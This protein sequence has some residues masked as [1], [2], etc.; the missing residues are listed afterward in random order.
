MDPAG[1]WSTSPG[2]GLLFVAVAV[3]PL[4]RS[5]AAFFL[6]FTSSSNGG[7]GTS[8]IDASPPLGAP[9]VVSFDFFGDLAML[10]VSI[11]GRFFGLL[12]IVSGEWA[13]TSALVCF[14]L[15]KPRLHGE[16]TSANLYGLSGF[17]WLL[18]W[19]ACWKICKFPETLHY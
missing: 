4:T 17:L 18:V 10:E 3:R 12:P 15:P 5:F 7:A 8:S 6:L 13:P 2:F 19:F 9:L 14:G 1:L 11:R 16:W